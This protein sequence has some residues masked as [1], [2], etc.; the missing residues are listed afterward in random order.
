MEFAQRL[1][2]VPPYLFVEISRKI[3]EKKSKGNLIKLLKESD[4]N[5]AIALAVIFTK[6]TILK[7]EKIACA[8]NSVKSNTAILFILEIS[9]LA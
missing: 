4:L 3:A 2:K 8:A 6:R 7:Y 5:F 9:W 1:D